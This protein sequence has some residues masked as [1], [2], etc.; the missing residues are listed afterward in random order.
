MILLTFT[1][2]S[3][4]ILEEKD[5][6]YHM[7][8]G[9]AISGISYPIIFKATNNKTTAAVGSVT[10]AVLA[11]V[12]KELLDERKYKGWDSRDILATGIGAIT[13]TVV[14]DITVKSKKERL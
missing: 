14:F 2:E 8:V 6:Q 13:V 4:T 9:A 12:G 11:G 7:L 1:A 3:Q 10:A 5:K